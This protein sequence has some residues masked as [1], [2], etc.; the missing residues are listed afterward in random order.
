MIRIKT[1]KLFY[2][3]VRTLTL[4]YDNKREFNIRYILLLLLFTH[5][6]FIV[7]QQ[8]KKRK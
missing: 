3:H 7:K 4:I 6:I 1:F 5:D 2:E 8:K